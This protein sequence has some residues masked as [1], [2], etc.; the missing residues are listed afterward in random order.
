MERE[1]KF[2]LPLKR[3]HQKL[4]D[5]LPDGEGTVSQINY[6]FDTQDLQLFRNNNVFRLRKEKGSNILTHKKGISMEDGY[7]QAFEEEHTITNKDAQEILQ[8]PSKL[9]KFFGGED[10]SGNLAQQLMLLGMG[11]TERSV[12]YLDGFKVELDA[13]TF[14]N[15][16]EDF[17]LEIETDT[18][19]EARKVLFRF[20]EEYAITYEP[21]A[22]TKYKRFLNNR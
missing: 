4:L 13:V 9:K 6:Y 1:I 14:P 12:F 16:E 21:Q 2:K 20:F 11:K 15:K 19:D 7:F 5:N 3:D 10:I 17:E 22:H 18:P 8:D